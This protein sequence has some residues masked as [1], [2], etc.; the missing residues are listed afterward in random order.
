M[1]HKCQATKGNRRQPKATQGNRRRPKATEG[2]RRQQATEVGT[3]CAVGSFSFFLFSSGSSI[4]EEKLSRG[5]CISTSSSVVV[6]VVVVVEL[7]IRFCKCSCQLLEISII[8]YN[9]SKIDIQYFKNRYAICLIYVKCQNIQLL[10]S[11]RF[12]YIYIIML[13]SKNRYENFKN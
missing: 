9:I 2:N 4:V 7:Q 6:V 3:G 11:Y 1:R 8:I 12:V 5:S 13:I 10:F